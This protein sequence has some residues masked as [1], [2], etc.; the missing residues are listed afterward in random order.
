MSFRLLE[1]P[2]QLPTNEQI[3]SVLRNLIDK[4]AL[5]LIDPSRRLLHTACGSLVV[6]M[7]TIFF[8][9]MI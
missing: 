9:L 2:R 4:Q 6:D 3:I 1:K 5:N 8:I 7:N